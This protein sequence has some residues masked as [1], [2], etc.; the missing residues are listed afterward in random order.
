M[1]LCELCQSPGGEVLWSAA[2]CRVV[3]VDDPLYPG[4]CRVIWN[5]HAGEMTDL[6]AE[7]RQYLMTVVF[8]V[9]AVVRQLYAPDKVNLASLGN[10][11]PHVHWH[12]IPRWRNDPHFPQ[13]IWG[14]QQ[15][16]A[17]ASR[18]TVTDAE[19]AAALATALA[20]LPPLP[21]S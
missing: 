20:A 21:R 3:L 12:V 13:P 16:D 9:E 1:P 6:S 14:T 11:T 5:A 2:P 18:S 15:R 19:L 10:M 8:A 7:E 17:L 4:F